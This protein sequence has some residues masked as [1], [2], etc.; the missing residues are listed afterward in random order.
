MFLLYQQLPDFW[1][2][3]NYLAPALGVLLAMF[4]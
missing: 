3:E 2:D 4:I 1:Y